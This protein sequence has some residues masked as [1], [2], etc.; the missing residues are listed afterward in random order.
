MQFDKKMAGAPC[1]VQP[2]IYLACNSGIRQLFFRLP[3][4]F[5]KHL[6]I[7]ESGI[8]DVLAESDEINSVLTRDLLGVESPKAQEGL[9]AHIGCQ[10]MAVAVLGDIPEV[11]LFLSDTVNGLDQA[12]G[13]EIGKGPDDLVNFF[14]Q[15]FKIR[16]VLDALLPAPAPL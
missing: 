4:N 16:F 12:A 13:K 2:A 14:V 15:Q 5:R 7:P 1:E 10:P 9:A 3:H 11:F 6:L 8:S